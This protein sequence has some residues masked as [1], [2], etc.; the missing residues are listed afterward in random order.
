MFRFIGLALLSV[1]LTAAPAPAQQ[2]RRTI[3]EAEI[4]RIMTVARDSLPR[5]PA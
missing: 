5:A 1:A 4:E 3:P 2:A